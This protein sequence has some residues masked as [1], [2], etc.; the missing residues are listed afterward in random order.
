MGALAALM[1]STP[2]PSPSSTVDPTLVTPGPW[3]FAAILFIAVAVILLVIDML[4][5][6][7]RARYRE[8]IGRELDAEA[9]AAGG[10]AEGAAAA[11]DAEDEAGE[12]EPTGADPAQSRD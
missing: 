10:S 3:G 7:R 9:G 12:G 6:I 2:T 11:S 4:R 1:A 8:E 5:R